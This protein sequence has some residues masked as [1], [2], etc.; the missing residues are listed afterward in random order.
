MEKHRLEFFYIENN[1]LKG[2]EIF[3]LQEKES[4]RNKNANKDR[5]TLC[6]GV[7]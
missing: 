5:K 3:H 6:L 1:F 2:C 7:V 4:E